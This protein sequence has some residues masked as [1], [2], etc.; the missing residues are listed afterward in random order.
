MPSELAEL[1]IFSSLT[2]EQL[3]IIADGMTRVALEP[4]QN[5]FLQGDAAARFFLLIDGRLKVTQLTEDGQQFIV[6]IVHP[7]ELLSLIHI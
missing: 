1:A 2:P 4:G 6:R 7:G 3:G 5:L